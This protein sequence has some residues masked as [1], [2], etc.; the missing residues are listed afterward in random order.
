VPVRFVCGVYDCW[1][2]NVLTGY[3]RNLSKETAYCMFGEG[4]ALFLLVFPSWLVGVGAVHLPGV[5][6]FLSSVSV[7]DLMEKS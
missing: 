7:S 4:V 5:G 3:A 2:R 1:H 6:V